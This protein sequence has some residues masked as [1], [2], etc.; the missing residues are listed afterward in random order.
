MEGS[1]HLSRRLQQVKVL[2]LAAAAAAAD[3]LYTTSSH[4][5]NIRDNLCW[6]FLHDILLI[7]AVN[8]AICLRLPRYA[9]SPFVIYFMTLSVSR[10]FSVDW[11]GYCWIMNGKRFGGSDNYLIWVYYTAICLEGLRKTTKYRARYTG[12]RFPYRYSN[13][14]PLECKSRELPLRQPDRWY[15]LLMNI[16]VKTC[17]RY[18]LYKLFVSSVTATSTF[19]VVSMRKPVKIFNKDFIF[20]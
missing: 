17:R 20:S 14:T 8:D 6:K 15:A 9:L 4:F 3:E 10:L 2:D 1:I 12:R 7:L 19:S 5:R 16:L 18:V 11:Y 13:W